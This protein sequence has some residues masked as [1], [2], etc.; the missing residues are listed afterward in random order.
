M[1]CP[2]GRPLIEAAA[3]NSQIMPDAVAIARQ[4]QATRRVCV[5]TMIAAG[6]AEAETASATN[7]RKVRAPVMVAVAAK[8]I[9]RTTTRGPS[10]PAPSQFI[11][12]TLGFTDRLET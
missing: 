11:G 10:I 12:L 1:D 2:G 8:C 5:R 7:V 3:N 9:A 6:L 4:I